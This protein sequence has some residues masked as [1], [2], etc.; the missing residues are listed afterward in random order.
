MKDI[1]SLLEEFTKTI[2][3][4]YVRDEKFQNAFLEILKEKTGNNN[5]GMI[6][7]FAID[8]QKHKNS[9]EAMAAPL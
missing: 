3:T 4:E 6:L 2:N 1:C 9:S 5:I 7:K 8:G